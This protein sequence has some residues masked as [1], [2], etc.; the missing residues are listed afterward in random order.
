MKSGRI[1]A[2]GAPAEVVTE[3]LVREVFALDAMVMPDPVS[4]TPLV[5][6]MGRHH[7][8]S[9]APAGPAGPAGPADRTRPPP[10]PSRRPR[11]TPPPTRNTV[12]RNTAETT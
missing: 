3:A 11:R 9:P 7:W 2:R 1:V 4:G 8:A 10:D 6:P 5:V 12:T